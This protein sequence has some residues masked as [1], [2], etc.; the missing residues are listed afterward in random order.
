MGYGGVED[1]KTPMTKVSYFKRERG[2]AATPPN[3]KLGGGGGG[4]GGGRGIFSPPQLFA[5]ELNSKLKKNYRQLNNM[6]SNY[7]LTL[8]T[9][10]MYHLN[11][12]IFI[13][14]ICKRNPSWICK[15]LCNVLLL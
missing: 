14:M 6:W 3:I 2:G 10:H 8:S 15:I 9:A 1:K 4:G 11:Y 5:I 12:K 13:F 7:T